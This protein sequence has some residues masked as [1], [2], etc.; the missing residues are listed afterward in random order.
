MSTSSR[1]TGHKV[2]GWSCHPTVK[3]S[4]PELFLSKRTAETKMEKRLWER[5]SSDQPKLEPIS[6]GGSKAQHYY[7]YSV[8][9]DRSLAW[10]PSERPNKQLAK[11]D[12]GTYIQPMD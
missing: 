3:N 2:E 1:K 11:T 9:T 7:C 10:Q 4:D 5:R 12:T 8:L 6:R